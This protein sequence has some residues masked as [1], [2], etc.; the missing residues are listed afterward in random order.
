MTL[1]GKRV[2]IVEDDNVIPHAWPVTSAPPERRWPGRWR[3]NGAA[4][5]IIAKVRAPSIHGDR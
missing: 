1:R 2:L 4:P 5:D 3:A